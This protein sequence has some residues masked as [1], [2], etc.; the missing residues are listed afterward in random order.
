MTLFWRRFSEEEEIGIL[1]ITYGFECAEKK[2]L[3]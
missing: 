2:L 1:S 3:H